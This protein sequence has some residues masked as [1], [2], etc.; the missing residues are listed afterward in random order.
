MSL[1]PRTGDWDHDMSNASDGQEVSEP[2]VHRASEPLAASD[3]RH[4]QDSPR[5]GSIYAP[6][7]AGAKPLR[8]GIMLNSSTQPG[9]VA[10]LL[11]GI[12][13]SGAAEIVCI[14][15][16]DIRND[17]QSLAARV[18]P[19]RKPSAKPFSRRAY[20]LYSRIDTALARRR[21]T[22]PD[23]TGLIDVSPWF[24]GVYW[25]VP[26]AMRMPPGMA[27]V[28][29]REMTAAEAPSGPLAGA[30]SATASWIVPLVFVVGPV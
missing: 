9:W 15:Q 23:R 28:P 18:P 27:L 10:R 8:L 12:T 6:A 29:A 4:V 11:D 20:A 22:Q 21:L 26:P 16:Y 19:G 7:P 1:D 25:S 14:I 2:L 5:V 24:A 30:F 17:V 13:T 3:R